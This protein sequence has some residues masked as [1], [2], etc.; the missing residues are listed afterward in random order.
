MLKVFNKFVIIINFIIIYISRS[1]EINEQFLTDLFQQL[2]EPVKFKGV[3]NRYNEFWGNT[4]NDSR[5]NQVFDFIQKHQLN[6]LNHG[7][8]TRAAGT[9]KSANDATKVSPSLE[10]TLS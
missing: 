4:S 5:G 10:P 9:S 3:F 1:H 6:L 8:Y 7:R 2:P